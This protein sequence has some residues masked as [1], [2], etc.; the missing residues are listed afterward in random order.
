MNN[1][2]NTID[3]D[4]MWRYGGDKNACS[5]YK[6]YAKIDRKYINPI[7]NSMGD[8]ALDLR[9]KKL[10][11]PHVASNKNRVHNLLE[12]IDKC[13]NNNDLEKLLEKE[14]SLIEFIYKVYEI[15]K[16]NAGELT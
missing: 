15:R 13:F 11:T 12:V 2:V 7:I 14:L 8:I 6:L 5:N 10:F 3:V 9:N 1:Q 4:Q 16:R